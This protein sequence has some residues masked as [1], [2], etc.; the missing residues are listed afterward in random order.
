MKLL[1]LDSSILGEGSASRAL[2][3]EL[4]ARWKAAIPGLEVQHV[5]LG[6]EPLP[7]LTGASLAKADEIEAARD[8]RTLADFLAA[9]VVVVGAPMY[10]FGVPTQLKAWIDR[11]LVAGQTFRYTANGPEGLAGGKR[12]IIVVSSG[13]VYAPN[14]P[15]E[16]VETYLKF[17]FGFIGITDVTVVRAEGLAISPENRQK[18]LD[19]AVAAIPAPPAL[20][21]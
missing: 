3:R 15:A 16:H 10:N 11:I 19:S 12:V 5:D 7:H 4:V 6:K 17:V 8:A 13:G 20:A 2:T 18:G 14:T 21:A 1:Q 9:D